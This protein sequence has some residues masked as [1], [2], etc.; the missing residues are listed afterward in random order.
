[1]PITCSIPMH[2]TDQEEFARLDYCVM[3]HAFESQNELGRLC[4]EMVHPFGW[5]GHG[6]AFNRP[7]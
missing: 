6:P 5:P 1:M 4:D 2:A 7:D 3:R